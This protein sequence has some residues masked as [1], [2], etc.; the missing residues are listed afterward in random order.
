MAIEVINICVMHCAVQ[1][2]PQADKIMA[3]GGAFG[4][5]C[6]VQTGNASF[7]HK[8]ALTQLPVI[9]MG[10]IGCTSEMLRLAE[11]LWRPA[12]RYQVLRHSRRIRFGRLSHQFVWQAC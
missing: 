5:K 7:K 11:L 3:L 1:P 2:S 10:W 6:G 8:V 12:A 9:E 4:P